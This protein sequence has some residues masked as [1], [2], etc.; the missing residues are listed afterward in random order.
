MIFFE[1]TNFLSFSPIIKIPKFLILIRILF[2]I[3][4]PVN[5]VFYLRRDI[6]QKLIKNCQKIV[7]NRKN[8]SFFYYSWAGGKI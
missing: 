1:I 3:L 7:K 5:R 2:T 4:Y 6:R 8:C